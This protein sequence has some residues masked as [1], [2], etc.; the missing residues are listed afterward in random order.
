LIESSLLSVAGGGLGLAAASGLLPLLL[1]LSPQ[2]L[3]RLD[4]VRVDLAVWTLRLP[5]HWL[6]A[7]SFSL[8]RRSADPR[9]IFETFA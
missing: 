1:R 8:A 5:L 4:E 2:D 3:P 7:L 6:P 9:L